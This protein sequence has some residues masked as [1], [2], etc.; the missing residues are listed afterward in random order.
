MVHLR[1]LVGHFVW[2]C[3][4]LGFRSIVVCFSFGGCLNSGG[5]GFG[6]WS[7]GG[8]GVLVVG[9]MIGLKFKVAQLNS[10]GGLFVLGLRLVGGSCFFGGFMVAWVVVFYN[11]FDS[12][13]KIN[14]IKTIKE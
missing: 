9:S 13:N 11:N 6:Y 2:V 8:L 12:I 4:W 1:I 3:T 5:F 14:S 10:G 7:V